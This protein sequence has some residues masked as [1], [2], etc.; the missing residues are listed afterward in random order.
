ML[1]LWGGRERCKEM[2]CVSFFQGMAGLY[3]PPGD[4]EFLV[5]FKMMTFPNYTFTDTIQLKTKIGYFGGF[6]G[7]KTI[8]ITFI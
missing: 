6:S 5:C 3:Q 7:S 8:N 4:Y 1:Q 2:C